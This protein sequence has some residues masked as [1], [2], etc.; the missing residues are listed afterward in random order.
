[1][2]FP[3][4]LKQSLNWTR[5]DR[6][7][8]RT[9]AGHHQGR[10][11]SQPAVESLESRVV[12]SA[13]VETTLNDYAPGDTAV[14]VGSG[15]VAGEAVALQVAHTDGTPVG[16]AGHDPWVVSADT[17]GNFT[18]SWYVNPDDSLNETFTLTAS[19]S[20]GS[21]D[22]ST[23]TDHGITLTGLSQTT[24]S[25]AGGTVLSVFSSSGDFGVSGQVPYQVFFGATGLTTT[26]IS[27][28]ELQVTTPVGAGSV[29]VT[30]KDKSG[31]TSNSLSFTYL[32]PTATPGLP[33]LDTGD[34][35]GAS[36]SDNITNDTDLTITVPSA[37]VGSS[38]QLFDGGVPV[39][40]PA[41]ASG[42]GVA[43]FSG[44]TFSHG[45]HT[46]TAKATATGMAQ[47]PASAPLTLVIDTVLPTISA[48]S[49]GQA[50]ADIHSGWN[51]TS[52]TV[53][54][55]FGDDASGDSGV[56]AGASSTGADLL[57]ASGTATG[58]V[59][60]VAG[61]SASVD[62]AIS[63][64]KAAPT[65][66]IVFPGSG[67]YIK[68]TWNYGDGSTPSVG[69]INGTSTD[70]G[71]PIDSSGVALVEVS[72][73]KVSGATAGTNGKY[74]KDGSFSSDT[75]FLLVAD[76][77]TS[78]ARLFSFLNF[79]EDGGYSVKA[80]GT[81]VA[82]NFEGSPTAAFTINVNV[83]EASLV[84]DS[85][86]PGKKML[87]IEGTPDADVINVS[88]LGSTG[89]LVVTATDGLAVFT[90]F[91]Y[92]GP[93]GDG[94]DA[95]SDPD[96]MIC[97]I[98]V[99]AGEGADDIQIAGGIKYQS[100]LYGEGGNDRLKGGA[101]LNM[102]LGGNGD[103]L[104]IGGGSRNIL[105]GGDGSDRIIGNGGDD[106][107]ISGMTSHDGSEDA[108]NAS[109]NEWGSGNAY[110]T[111]SSRLRNSLHAAWLGTQSDDGDADELTGSSG[112]DLFFAKLSG[113]VLDKITDLG[114][115]IGTTI[116]KKNEEFYNI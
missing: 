102:L 53:S 37:V 63:I 90:I 47:S 56:D 81:D 52:V 6:R 64:D 28:T 16:G 45:T 73:Q 104:I 21:Y 72:I 23:F 77:T 61:N 35:H 26:L 38:V 59:V 50:Y 68:S 95:D 3:N 2:Y 84:P 67:T 98:R 41:I 66:T 96:G 57:S 13:V 36:P 55:T 32:T 17:S 46:I 116:N 48:T 49:D 87:L 1:M 25:T 24:G 76:G 71:A 60:D 107:L 5:S 101:G 97:R 115:T 8:A 11:A 4:L 79:P 29:S 89:G 20:Q 85:L 70:P 51:N 43:T 74:W 80:H 100:W 12:L 92:G 33:D 108:L 27:A 112:K 93:T 109:L 111:R 65:S 54:Y 22:D 113:G 14:I 106:V 44:L 110:S 34:D 86:N 19:G 78:W 69:D 83:A 105:I 10:L 15:F 18:T 31:H 39:G 91:T 62:K 58:T 40:S 99:L 94:S 7:R 103:D 30:V 114:K 88:P 75:E 9:R 42:G 82:G